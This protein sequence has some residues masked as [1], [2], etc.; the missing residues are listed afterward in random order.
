MN[1]GNRRRICRGIEHL[2]IEL[3]LARTAQAAGDDFAVRR[4]DHQA[5]GDLQ[6]IAPG[7]AFE[8]PPQLVGSPQQRHVRGMFEI[9]EP[10]H[11][12]A[13]VTRS[14]IVR[15]LELLDAE[16]ALAARRRVR[17]GGAA[18]AAKPDDNH[19]EC[20]DTPR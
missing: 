10:D 3:M 19:I 20:A 5:A 4:S 16:H 8:A 6:Q 1:A 15:R 14:L 17:R 13:A 2:V 18:H 7:R 9:R 11:A 12:R